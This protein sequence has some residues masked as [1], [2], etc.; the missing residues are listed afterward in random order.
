MNRRIESVFTIHEENTK[1]LSAKEPCTLQAREAGAN[2]DHVIVF[3]CFERENP[4]GSCTWV[5]V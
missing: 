2:N 3:H 1:A 5:F 4:P